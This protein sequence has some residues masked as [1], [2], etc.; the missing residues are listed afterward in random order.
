LRGIKSTVLE[1]SPHRHPSGRIIM[2][3]NAMRVLEKNGLADAVRRDSWTYLTRETRDAAG[4]LLA[5]RDYR[6]LYE[7]GKLAPGALV[8]RAHLLD[9][10]FRSLPPGTVLWVVHKNIQPQADRRGADGLHLVQRDSLRRASPAMGYRRT[11]WSWTT[12]GC[13]VLH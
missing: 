6:P 7:S 4:R 5:T 3:P 1:R 2:N 8:H 12:S 10:L 9:V 13:A 11:A